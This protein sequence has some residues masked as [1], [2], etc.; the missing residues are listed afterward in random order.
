MAVTVVP[1]EHE[2]EKLS[3]SMYNQKSD[4]LCKMKFPERREFGIQKRLKMYFEANKDVTHR[5]STCQE[6]SRT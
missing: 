3:K 6:E 5:Y 2:V 4:Y 1:A